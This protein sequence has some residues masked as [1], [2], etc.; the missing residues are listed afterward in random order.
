MWKKPFPLAILCAKHKTMDKLPA[1][2]QPLFLGAYIQPQQ[3]LEDS[4]F[5]SKTWHCFAKKERRW[6]RLRPKANLRIWFYENWVKCSFYWYHCS[7]EWSLPLHQ[8]ESFIHFSYPE[9]KK[10]YYNDKSF[11]SS[12]WCG[13]FK[14]NIIWLNNLKMYEVKSGKIQRMRW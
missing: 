8:I 1:S 12:R 11:N 10:N 9:L 3:A 6:P 2:F 4:D 5:N 7:R 13:D 14:H